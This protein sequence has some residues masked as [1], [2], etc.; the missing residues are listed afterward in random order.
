MTEPNS[1]E[2]FDEIREK[3]RE[4]AKQKRPSPS[5]DAAFGRSV[6][7]AW[8]DLDAAQGKKADESPSR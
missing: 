8:A 2:F 1:K 4:E 7:D 3:V 5:V 6:N